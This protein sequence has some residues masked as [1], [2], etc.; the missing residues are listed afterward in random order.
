MSNPQDA[1]K[2]GPLLRESEWFGRLARGLLTDQSAADD[3]M[4]ETWLAALTG[5]EIQAPCAWL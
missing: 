2:L 3:L 4:Q 5:P 1:S